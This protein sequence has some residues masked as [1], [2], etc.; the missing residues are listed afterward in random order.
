MLLLFAL[1]CQRSKINRVTGNI[2]EM[3]NFML[4]SSQTEFQNL[5]CDLLNLSYFADCNAQL[6]SA[7]KHSS[8][9]RIWTKI[10]NNKFL[11]PFL[12]S[13]VNN[14]GFFGAHF[15]RAKQCSTKKNIRWQMGLDFFSK[16]PTIS[17]HFYPF[18]QKIMIIKNSQ[19]ITLG[20][21]NNSIVK[22]DFR[23]DSTPTCHAATSSVQC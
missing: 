23:K 2:G 19:K 14:Y 9:Q 12:K 20:W 17:I 8:C 21:F 18:E 7:C 6:Q 11:D 22:Y 15:L 10:S 13:Y 16:S 1:N 4:W 5:C 3:S